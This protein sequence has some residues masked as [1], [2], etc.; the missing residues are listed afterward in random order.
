ME[1]MGRESRLKGMPA[2]FTGAII[3]CALWGGA[4]P[5][6]KTGYRI[7]GI[8]PG[9]TGLQIIF[10]GVRFV[11][12][13]ILAVI[14]GSILRGHFLKPLS[15]SGKKIFI[16]SLLQ[17]FLQYLFFYIGLA[18]TSGVNGSILVSTNVFVSLLVAAL[19][20]KQ[21]RMTVWKA[22][23]CIIGFMGVVVLNLDG[24]RLDNGFTFL[25][26]GCM[27]LSTVATSFS[28]VLIKK[29]S[30]YEDPF[31]LSSYQFMEGGLILFVTGIIIE[32]ITGSGNTKVIDTL[33]AN[34]ETGEMVLILLILAGISAIAYSLWGELLKYNPVSKVTVFGFTIPVF[35]VLFSLVFLGE[36]NQHTA[37]A[38]F[39][40]LL[41]IAVG[42]LM[43]QR[44]EEGW[45]KALK[46]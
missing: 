30:K 1:K 14:I 8:G 23:G 33:K 39:L 9:D 13:G 43:V 12:A 31:T 6:I 46:R 34:G 27:I 5:G 3:C 28:A 29:Y 38:L 10:A 44:P 21:E 18:H 24:G 11:L 32:K 35:G 4:F 15:G 7:M 20:F 42:T 45:R 40:S 19:I 41:L 2:V 25:G 36:K 17:T 26:E 37:G 16:L 22:L